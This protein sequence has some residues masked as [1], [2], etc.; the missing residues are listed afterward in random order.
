MSPQQ[1]LMEATMRNPTTYVTLDHREP[2]GPSLARDVCLAF[3]AVAL[4]V[5]CMVSA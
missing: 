4:F 3:V 1:T 5:A 2:Y